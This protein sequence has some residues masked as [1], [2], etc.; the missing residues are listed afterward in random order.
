MNGEKREVEACGLSTT[1]SFSARVYAGE[2]ASRGAWPWMAMIVK[3]RYSFVNG[4][5][6]Q[7]WSHHCGGSI[8]SERTILSAAHCFDDMSDLKNYRIFLGKW[9]ARLGLG[10]EQEFEIGEV[11]KHAEFTTHTFKNDIALIRLRAPIRFSEEVRPVCLPDP[12]NDITDES[13][14]LSGVASCFVLGWGHMEIDVS[15]ILCKYLDL[16]DSFI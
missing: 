2:S 10:N 3:K 4:E 14:I 5:W 6:I 9:E 13:Y 8:I 12:T 11:I 1:L 7:Q 16:T 15:V